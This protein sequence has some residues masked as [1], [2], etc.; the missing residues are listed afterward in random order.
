MIPFVKA[1][2]CGNDFLII[3]E[4]FAAVQSAENSYA[5]VARRLCRRNESIGADGIEFFSWLAE[6]KGKIHLYN[7]DG[8][9]AEISGNGTRCVAA[10]MA[11][12]ANAGP[13]NQIICETD[14]G[15]RSC[16]IVSRE[17][18][19]FQIAS[20][21]GVPHVKKS[22]VSLAGG[23]MVEGAIVSTGNPHFVIFV[24]SPDFEVQ[25]R[26]WQSI[27]SE[28]ATHA[29]FPQHTNVEFVHPIS[30]G[31]IEI[32][33]F[34]RGVGPTTSSGT[35]TC[36]SA[37]ASMYLRGAAPELRVSAPGGA[38]TVHWN[39]EDSE[40]VLTGPAE[41]ICSGEAF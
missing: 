32:R 31:E 37:A 2:A 19:R 13:D 33:I 9:T 21:M 38:Q 7:A 10:W 30:S 3:Q 27:G 20:S 1:H 29:R 11:Y 23:G 40:I 8:S 22:S 36:A 25:G 28:I 18:H 26:T 6:G 4:G 12:E 14:A 41:L 39:G 5:E 24:D 17:G 35:G 16:R 15:L 34:E